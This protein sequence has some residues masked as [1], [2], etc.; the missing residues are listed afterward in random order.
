MHRSMDTTEMVR[1]CKEMIIPFMQATDS[2]TLIM[3]CTNVYHNERVYTMLR[4]AYITP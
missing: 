2:K 3:D 1:C 4:D